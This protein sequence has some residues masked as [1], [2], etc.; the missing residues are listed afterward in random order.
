[1]IV[2]GESISVLTLQVISNGAQLLR[3]NFKRATLE[4][5]AKRRCRAIESFFRTNSLRTSKIAIRTSVRIHVRIHIR[6][7]VESINV[8][9][10]SNQKR[11]MG[12]SVERK[13]ELVESFVGI[14]AWNVV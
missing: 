1:M 12:C 13:G 7:F 10:A 2:H 14:Y 6:S 4:I 5:N 9:S 11:T 3:L 8:R